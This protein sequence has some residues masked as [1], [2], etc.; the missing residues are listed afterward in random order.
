MGSCP[1]YLMR[2]GSHA[3]I[4]KVINTFFYLIIFI[5]FFQ[6]FMINRKFK[7]ALFKIEI[8]CNIMLRPC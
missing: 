4:L 5:L 1:V 3:S 8:I 6:D 2:E 7:K